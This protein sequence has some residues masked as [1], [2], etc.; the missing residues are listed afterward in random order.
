MTTLKEYHDFF[1]KVNKRIRDERVTNVLPKLD[2]SKRA[3]SEGDK[4][5]PP[6]KIE[7][8][9]KELKKLSKECG[10][11]NVEIRF[12][13]QHNLWEVAFVSSQCTDHC[14]HWELA[15]SAEYRQMASKFKQI[16]ANMEPPFIVEPVVRAEAP[17]NGNEEELSDA[18]RPEVEKTDKKNSK[19]TKRKA[20]KPDVVE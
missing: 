6:K 20:K 19:N 3:D 13:E 1:N 15:S 9:E 2:L 17:T 12:D 5:T 16:E 11:K 8:L 7:K 10:Y 4:K 18:E 14:I